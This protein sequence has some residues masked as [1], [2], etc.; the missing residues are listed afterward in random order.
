[1]P[2]L[3]PV[4]PARGVAPRAPQDIFT[5]KFDPIVIQFVHGAAWEGDDRQGNGAAGQRS[6]AFIFA[7]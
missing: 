1:M 3:P 2:P 4:S 6:A 5:R 7:F